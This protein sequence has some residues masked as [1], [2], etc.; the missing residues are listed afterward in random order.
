MKYLSVLF[1][2]MFLS[3]CS[4]GDSSIE[5]GNV[6][7]VE[8]G[9]TFITS[10]DLEISAGDSVELILYRPDDEI[11]NIN[12][13]QLSGD[14]INI[15]SAQAKV[16]SFTIPQ[17]GNYVFEVAYTA[18]GERLSEQVQIDAGNIR[19][20]LVA[21]LGH[22]VVEGGNVSL[23][24][25]FDQDIKLNTINW[26]QISGPSL[27]FDN[28]NQDPALLI[29][30]VPQVIKDTI[31][32]IELQGQDDSGQ[33]YR[34]SVS[35]LVENTPTIPSQ[36]YF[37]SERLA[38]VRPY[39]RNSPY[40]N[41]IVGCVYSNQLTSSCELGDLPPLGADTN[42]QT[43][44]IEQVMQRVVVS[45]DWMGDRFKQYLENFDQHDD[46]KNLLR[47]ATAVVLSYDVRPSF[48]WAATGAIYLDPNNLWMTA[49]ERDTINEAPDYRSNFGNNLQFIIPWRY[50]KNNDY[51][52]FDY[53]IQ[54]RDNRNMAD[55]QFELADLLYHE[56]G[57]ANDYFPKEEWQTFTLD[58]RFLDA[59]LHFDE[60]SEE[61]IA[62]YPLTSDEM[63]NLAAVRFLGA[64]ATPAQKAYLPA[65]V[66]EFYHPDFA[67]GFYNYTNE[68]EDLGILFESLMMSIRYGIQ[69]DTAVI[70]NQQD[71][72]L[73]SWGE[74][75]RVA[76]ANILARAKFIA[77]R[78]LPELDVS[79]ADS[80]PAPTPMKAG[81]SWFDNLEL[82]NGIPSEQLSLKDNP[83]VRSRDSQLREFHQHG[84][85]LPKH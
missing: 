15:L 83:G 85:A 35:I 67:N 79:L 54:D 72:Y 73:V 31:V 38:K 49:Q 4:G 64:E 68:K 70:S 75:G 40:A 25:Y 45:H 8:P 74:R 19:P 30:D 16:V 11:S 13:V 36:A 28:D 59:A 69:R 32:T 9:N 46:F 47:A 29:F 6:S 58:S 20:K 27:V 57:H 61:M 71:G 53:P 23:R 18:G 1:T 3:A 22:S 51:V 37:D 56:L 50:V 24:A 48:Y 52:T 34:D 14:P 81:V 17:S 76:R 43:P 44:T 84:K 63:K 39:D 80:L 60:I 7:P 62:L 42:K 78:L 21:R 41:T 77:K 2:V 33:V 65:D 55:I 26:R 82:D 5:G 10:N 12:W 66:V